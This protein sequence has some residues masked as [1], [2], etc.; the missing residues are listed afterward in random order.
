MWFSLELSN[1]K[2]AYQQETSPRSEARGWGSSETLRDITYDFYEYSLLLPQHKKKINKAFLEWFIGLTEGCGSFIVSKNKVYFDITLNLEDIQ[3]IYYIKKELGLGKV[4]IRDG[5]KLA[6]ASHPKCS[7]Y[8]SSSIN[9]LRLIHLFNGNLSSNTKKEEFKKWL[10]TFNDLYNMN[11]YFKDQL[12]KISLESGWLSGFI[13]GDSTNCF[14]DLRSDNSTL[15]ASSN[16]LGTAGCKL[17]IFHKDFYVIKSIRD[18][19]L[20]LNTLESKNIK[21]SE[22]GWIFYCSSFT[23]LKVI[24]NY[25][26]RYK[27]KTKKSLLFTKWHKIHKEFL[28]KKLIK[29]RRVINKDIQK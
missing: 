15:N 18:V 7:F 14:L 1:L 5:E 8:V 11:V 24:I 27:L 16:L 21:K 25:F 26:S 19:F 13:D 4:L 22:G 17:E 6:G 3:V 20:N 28:N 12:V 23:K 9:F 10:N 29:R 2:G